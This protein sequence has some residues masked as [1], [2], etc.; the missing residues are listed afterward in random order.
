M[1]RAAQ[2]ILESVHGE[3]AASQ[4]RRI[5]YRRLHI[6]VAQWFLHRPDL[7]A[8][9]EQRRRN[10][11]PNGMTT[12]ACGEPHRTTGPAHGPLQPTCMDVMPANESCMGVFRQLVGGKHV[13][14][15]PKAAGTGVCS[16]Q[17]ER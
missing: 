10:A 9:L 1:T 3:S 4:P 6:V 14:P 13:W 8:L 15:Q 7:V 2:R 5:P 16:C 11:V 12:E 17:G